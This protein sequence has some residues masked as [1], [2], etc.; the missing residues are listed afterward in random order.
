MAQI[1]PRRR[2]ARRTR[3]NDPWDPPPLSKRILIVLHQEHSTPGRV[4]R[5]LVERGYTLDIRRT[6]C[7]CG[8]PESMDA[9][10]GA[11]VFGGPMS[12][13]DEADWCRRQTEWIGTVLASGKPYLGLCLGAQMLARHLGASVAAHPDGH[14]EIG[15]FSLRPTPEGEAFA[16][17]IGAPWPGHVYHWHREGF[18]VPPGAVSLAEGD[19][20]PNQA[21]RI[22]NAYGLQFH[23][24]VT[25]AM[26]CRWTVRGHERLHLPGARQRHE[27]LEG[28]FVHDPAVRRWLDAFLDHW[29]AGG[30][31]AARP[32]AGH[33]APAL[34]LAG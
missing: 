26:M 9:H 16:R 22:G 32:A 21:F 5:L 6:P 7:G 8:L 20:F 12:A 2:Q 19:T 29:L 10:D 23:P 18:D 11:V 24:E 34:A 33:D 27:H 15:Y 3:R 13:N 14:A 17:Q 1:V 4:G 25:Y 31:A 30:N 28:W